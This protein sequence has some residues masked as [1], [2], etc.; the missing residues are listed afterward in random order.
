[1]RG[2]IDQG[3]GWEMECE[4]QSWQME[5]PFTRGFLFLQAAAFLL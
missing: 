4:G 1:M 2:A 5:E 3:I